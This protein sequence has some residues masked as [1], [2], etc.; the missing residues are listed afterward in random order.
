MSTVLPPPEICPQSP[1]ATGG[2]PAVILGI[3]NRLLTD[4][5]I[6]VHI[7][8]AVGALA[9][10]GW[11]G[12]RLR[13]RDGG[14]IGLSLLAE[15]D[16]AARL[17]AVDAMELGAAPGTVAL[18]L[19]TEMDRAL[20]GIKHSAHE[21]ALSDLIQAAALSD[22]LPRER[23]LIGVQPQETGW[24]LEPTAAVAAAIPE[25]VETILTLLEDWPHDR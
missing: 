18:F 4:D 17:I 14:T 22:I 3:G 11:A 5:G 13:I 9:Q 8:E 6:G 16:P 10:A 15:I 1:A 23:A 20:S 19:G 24:G 7:A 21:V 2:P 12:G 25:A